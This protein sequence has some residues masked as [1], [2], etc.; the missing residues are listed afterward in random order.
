MQEFSHLRR[1]VPV[2][3]VDGSIAAD[4]RGMVWLDLVAL[5]WSS[6]YPLGE[7]KR[8]GSGAGPV[9][10]LRTGDPLFS[11]M[12]EVEI[13]REPRGQVLLRPGEHGDSPGGWI[14][15]HGA[16]QFPVSGDAELG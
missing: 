4:A 1:V 16:D 3:E 2:S 6:C 13:L 8:S 9:G 10:L 15:Y 11:V 5:P 14:S 7:R 12:A